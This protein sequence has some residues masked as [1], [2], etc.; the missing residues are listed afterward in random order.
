MTIKIKDSAIERPKSEK[1]SGVYVDNR[2]S[3]DN[4]I[5]SPCCHKNQKIND[6][7]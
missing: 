7:G 6:L 4:H 3:F 5:T 1:I 2:L